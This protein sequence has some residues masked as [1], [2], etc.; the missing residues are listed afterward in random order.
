MSCQYTP[1]LHI[2][3]KG[4]LIT[5][6]TFHHPTCQLSEHFTKLNTVTNLSHIYSK[7]SIN[8]YLSYHNV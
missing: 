5:E 8:F 2:L 7:N 1:R 6:P 4:A 3:D